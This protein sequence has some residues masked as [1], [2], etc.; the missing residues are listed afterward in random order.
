MAIPL[1]IYRK[2]ELSVTEEGASTVDDLAAR[3]L[4]DWLT[5]E[6]TMR[7]K[8]EKRVSKVDEKLIEERLKALGYV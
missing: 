5:K 7:P 8:R 1:P 2:L 3:I 6:V 4:R